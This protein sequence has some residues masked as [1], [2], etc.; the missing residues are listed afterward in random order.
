MLDPSPLDDHNRSQSFSWPCWDLVLQMTMLEPSPLG[1]HIRSQSFRWP[2]WDI[3]LQFTMLDLSPLGGHFGTQSF[4][5]PYW[6]LTN[7]HLTK[8]LLV[9]YQICSLF[10]YS[11]SCLILAEVLYI[12]SL[13]YF[14]IDV[15]KVSD[16][17]TFMSVI[18][19]A[20]S[21]FGDSEQT[22]L[23]LPQKSKVKHIAIN[24]KN[25]EERQLQLS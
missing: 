4:R 19:I 16:L 6:I 20:P 25:E 3:V 14:S 15:L 2:C 21:R 13:L 24:S 1:D 12:S 5:C 10:F 11:K 17:R 8:M 22:S 7:A 18:V 23:C 9:H